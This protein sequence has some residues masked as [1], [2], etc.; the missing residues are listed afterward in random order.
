[1]VKMI[2]IKLRKFLYYFQIFVVYNSIHRVKM[3]IHLDSSLT[4][5][6]DQNASDSQI[7]L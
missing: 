1:M 2:R 3:S 7:T 5:S 4:D 6:P